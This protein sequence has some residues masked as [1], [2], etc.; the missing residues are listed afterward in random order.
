MGGGGTWTLVTPFSAQLEKAPEVCSGGVSA[1]LQARH[2]PL[3]R[4]RGRSREH[5]QAPWP[6]ARSEPEEAK[7]TNLTLI[8]AGQSR[9][10]GRLSCERR[11]GRFRL[12]GG[13]PGGWGGA[14]R[15]PIPNWAGFARDRRRT[16]SG[17]G[18]GPWGRV[19]GLPWGSA[20]EALGI[21]SSGIAAPGRRSLQEP[22]EPAR[23]N[24]RHPSSVKRRL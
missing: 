10:G 2:A 24:A 15:E 16:R 6:S 7:E 11:G 22:R 21:A 4:E 19:G 18:V 12:G 9:P 20:F 3:P 14:G 17:A 13:G 8:A 5:P 23:G 1:R